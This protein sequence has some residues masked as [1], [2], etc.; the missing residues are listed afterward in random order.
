MAPHYYY[1]ESI[2]VSEP[3]ASLNTFNIFILGPSKIHNIMI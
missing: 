3:R 2:R 1:K